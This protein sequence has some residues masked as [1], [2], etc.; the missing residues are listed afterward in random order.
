MNVSW[1]KDMQILQRIGDT[2]DIWVQV[3][4]NWM[5]VNIFTIFCTQVDIKFVH[6]IT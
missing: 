6:N 5:P 4:E 1:Q 3:W 2:E